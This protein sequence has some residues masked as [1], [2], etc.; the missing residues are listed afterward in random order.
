MEA[1][2]QGE[3]WKKQEGREAGRGERRGALGIQ[4]NQRKPTELNRQTPGRAG[5]G[6]SFSREA[7]GMVGCMWT[8][9]ATLTHRGYLRALSSWAHLQT[10]DL[11]PPGGQ[12]VPESSLDG[13]PSAE[14]SLHSTAKKTAKP[15]IST[16]W[17]LRGTE[18]R[19]T[20]GYSRWARTCR[21]VSAGRLASLGRWTLRPGQRGPSP[22]PMAPCYMWAQEARWPE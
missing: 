7:T 11:R 2:R 20:P 4:Q 3:E 9:Q 16:S 19:C 12:W 8:R 6:P 21:E 10:I 17:H 5:P 13:E 15:R 18:C 14:G 22:L 1:E